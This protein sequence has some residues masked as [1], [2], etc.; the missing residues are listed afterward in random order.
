[1]ELVNNGG[2]FTAATVN[3]GSAATITVST[4][5]G[6]AT[7]LMTLSL[8]QTDPVTSECIN[9]VV[10]AAG[11][12][13]VDIGEGDSP[14]FAVFASA[15]EAIAL[16]PANGRVFLRFSDELGEVRGTTSVA[17]ENRQ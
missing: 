7:L 3:V 5:T 17:V 6:R 4:D 2:F 15:S 14:I 13:V 8:C 16:D 9:P 11:P 10:P 12:V 1:M